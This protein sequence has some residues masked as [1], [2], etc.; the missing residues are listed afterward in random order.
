MFDLELFTLAS[1]YKTGPR[2]SSQEEKRYKE[3]LNSKNVHYYGSKSANDSDRKAAEA[4]ARGYWDGNKVLLKPHQASHIRNG[5]EWWRNEMHRTGEAHEADTKQ[6]KKIW[7]DVYHP[8]GSKVV[9]L[10]M[11]NP[12]RPKSANVQTVY[13]GIG[14]PR[15]SDYTSGGGLNYSQGPLK[16]DGTPDM[17]YKSNW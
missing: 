5:A 11:F 6:P 4:V 3:A 8:D 14:R 12:G 13:Q 16:K 7:S 15:S 9:D 10:R 2:H 1:A 17:R